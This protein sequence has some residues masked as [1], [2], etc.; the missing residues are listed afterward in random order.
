MIMRECMGADI[1]ILFGQTSAYTLSYPLTTAPVAISDFL[2]VDPVK[3]FKE[4]YAAR[5]TQVVLGM[6][7]YQAPQNVPL[8]F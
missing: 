5:H 6:P 8:N 4:N 1:L 3:L 7:L 2:V